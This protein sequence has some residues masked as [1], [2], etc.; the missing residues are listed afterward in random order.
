MLACNCTFT[1]L[2]RLS[3]FV[4]LTFVQLD[5]TQIKGKRKRRARS[6]RFEL[7]LGFTSLLG[8][9]LFSHRQGVCQCAGILCGSVCICLAAN[10]Q[11][12]SSAGETS[13]TF[14]IFP[15][16]ATKKGEKKSALH[17]FATI[18]Q[19][20]R[21]RE[22]ASGRFL[23]LSVCAR[24][25]RETSLLVS[26]WLAQPVVHAKERVTSVLAFQDFDCMMCVF[27]QILHA[28][29]PPPTCSSRC[30]LLFVRTAQASS[31][32]FSAMMS[33]AAA[34]R[35]ASS[36]SMSLS[37]ARRTAATVRDLEHVI[38]LGLCACARIGTHLANWQRC[39][40]MH[41]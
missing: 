7:L 33:I 32:C 11:R 20:V 19:A 3:V 36:S 24:R 16:F 15:S 25:W 39:W 17:V 38:P 8:K 30:K 21:E 22:R 13:R 37:F 28:L 6:D 31:I 14:L 26:L 40:S 29:P 18:I 9:D 27:S 23:S 4:V 41:A 2:P 12:R 1:D 35:A 5:F 34:A 10:V